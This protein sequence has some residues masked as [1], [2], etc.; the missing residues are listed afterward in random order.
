MA[1]TVE[2]ILEIKGQT[3][4]WSFPVASGE[5]IYKGTIAVLDDDGYLRNLS[6]TYVTQAKIVVFVADGSANTSPAATTSAGSISGT[7][8]V[9]SAVAGDKT[10]RLCYLDGFVRATFTSTTQAN[11]GKTQYASDNFTVDEAQN[12]GVKIGTLVTYIDADEG[13]IELNKFYQHDGTI[14]YKQAI[15]RSSTAGGLFNITAGT[16]GAGTIDVGV[17]ATLT[18]NDALIDGVASSTTGVKNSHKNAG[19]NGTHL[20][21]AT[22]AQYITG[23]LATGASGSLL[24]GTVG[25]WYRYWE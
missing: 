19:T 18:S 5:T 24:A 16:S 1:V 15:T 2:K 13:W 9:G 11:I 6:S 17:A 20:A 4:E 23:T 25:I 12:S 22:S 21:K 3:K 7:L 14:F 10:V 8:E